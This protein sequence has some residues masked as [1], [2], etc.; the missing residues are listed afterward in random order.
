[1]TAAY[2][3]GTARSFAFFVQASAPVAFEPATRRVFVRF[4]DTAGITR[5]RTSVAV[6][7]R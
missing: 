7:T 4:T 3:G 5:G 1:V 6:R 2:G